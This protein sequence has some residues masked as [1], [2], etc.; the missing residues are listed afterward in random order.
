VQE[1]YSGNGKVYL[2]NKSYWISNQKC[3]R[4]NRKQ[5]TKQRRLANKKGRAKKQAKKLNRPYSISV[6]MS[7]KLK[8]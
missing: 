8:T 5:K 7:Y 4:M 1:A 3:Q 2:L 6:D